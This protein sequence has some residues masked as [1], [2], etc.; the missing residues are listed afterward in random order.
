MRW[1]QGRESDNVEDRRSMPRGPMV[2][3]GGLGTIAI[4]LLVMFLGGD[5][6]VV[7]DQLKQQQQQGQPPGPVAEREFTPEEQ[8]AEKLVRVVLADT[9]DVWTELFRKLGKTYRKTKVVLFSGSVDRACGQASSAVGPFYYPGDQQVYIDLSCFDELKRKFH[10]PGDFAQAYV[11]AH[12]IGHHVQQQLGISDQVALQRRQMSEREFNALSVRVELQADFFAGVWA[13]HAN[14]A[15][16]ILESGDIEA[17][18]NAATA[19]GDD[20]LQKQARG[21]VIPD[22][23]THGTSA[24]R[25]RWFRKGIETGDLN[26]GDTFKAKDL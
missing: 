18:I 26:Q 20:K 5:P 19:I 4:V 21:Y 23:F 7:L 24:Q 17:A 15:R 12:E 14:K 2:V 9:E 13:Y 10:A 25:V 16:N 22:S 6:G 1:E 11:L 3:G 8:R